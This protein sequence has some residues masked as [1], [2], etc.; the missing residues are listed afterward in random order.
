MCVGTGCTVLAVASIQDVA[1]HLGFLH[2]TVFIVALIALL[3]SP[4]NF[5]LVLFTAAMVIMNMLVDRNH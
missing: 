4:F 5:A 1:A 2:P 3:A